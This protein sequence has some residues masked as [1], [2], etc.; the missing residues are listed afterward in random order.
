MFVQ[1]KTFPFE[2]LV[3]MRRLESLLRWDRS[4][5]RCVAARAGSYYEP[6]DRRRH[7][8]DKWRHIDNPTKA[9]KELQSRIYRAIL[10]TLPFGENIVGGIKGRSTRDNA[11]A[12]VNAPTLV[13]L[14]IKSCF[15]SVTDLA[16]YEVFRNTL[17]YSGEIADLMTKLTTFQHRLPQGA[18]TSSVLAN[19]VMLPLHIEVAKIAFVYGLDWSMYVDDIAFSGERAREAIGPTIAALKNIG[20]AVRAA[21]VKV[22]T[23]GE[24]QRL[25]GIVIN[26]KLS[27]GRECIGEIRASILE[28]ANRHGDVFDFEVASMNGRIS[29][30][31][32]VNAAQGAS[33]WRLASAVL[34]KAT[35]HGTRARRGEIRECHRMSRHRYR[36]VERK[37]PARLPVRDRQRKLG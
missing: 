28:L 10:Q 24:Q 3:S 25:T 5:I 30:V 29:Y 13:T 32:S 1:T 2:P 27:A 17:E 18:P 37:I 35:A 26:R 31:A 33:L 19:L 14:D 36:P 8:D 6:F 16:I 4:D 15:P 22:M 23:A 20:H 21:K 9:L 12:H 11:A 7:V 34:P